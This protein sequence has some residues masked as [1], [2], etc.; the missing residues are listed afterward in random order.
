MYCSCPLLALIVHQSQLTLTHM[1]TLATL[2][3]TCSS[4]S[5]TSN[6]CAAP[7][8]TTLMRPRGKPQGDLCMAMDGSD[9]GSC[10]SVLLCH[11]PQMLDANATPLLGV[12]TCIGRSLHCQHVPH[13]LSTLLARPHSCTTA[14]LCLTAAPPCCTVA[15]CLVHTLHSAP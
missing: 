4:S 9:A 5:N 12:A 6:Q 14:L 11:L 8:H 2:F 1:V 7:K 13:K 10:S 3:C 15:L